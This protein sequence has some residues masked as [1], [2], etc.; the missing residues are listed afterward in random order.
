MNKALKRFKRVKWTDTRYG[1][2]S[3][4]LRFRGLMRKALNN[5]ILSMHELAVGAICSSNA[6]A[7][8]K[9]LAVNK[10]AVAAL[11]AINKLV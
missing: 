2:I 8:E 10:S 3:E 7:E 5:T 11:K 6:T 1:K 4:R 9:Q